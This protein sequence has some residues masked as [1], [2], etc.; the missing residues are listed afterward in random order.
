MSQIYSQS[1]DLIAFFGTGDTP[2]ADNF[3]SL[4]KSKAVYDGSLPKISGSGTSTGSFQELKTSK[5]NA[6]VG[7]NITLS[8]SLT[9]FTDKTYN[10]GSDSSRI[11]MVN[12]VTASINDVSSSLIPH[13]D[14]A[15]DLGSNDKLYSNIKGASGSFNIISSSL[16]PKEDNDLDLGTS[17]R[18]WKD[19][20]ITGTSYIDK[21]VNTSIPSVTGSMIV[22]GALL[23]G[24]DDSFDLGASGT[25]WK[26]L[27]V[28]GT[29]YIDTLSISALAKDIDIH[30][31][32]CSDNLLQ[33]SGTIHAHADNTY[34]LGTSTKE[35]KDLYIDGV[36]Y[37]DT[38]GASTGDPGVDAYIATATVSTIAASGSY[39][40][41]IAISGSLVPGND[42]SVDL[43][44]STKEFKDL[45]ID[46]VANIDTIGAADDEVANAYVNISTLS[47]INASGSVTDSITISGSL[48]PGANTS[49]HNLGTSSAQWNDLHVGGIAFIDHLSGSGTEGD[50]YITASV[51]IV[52]GVDNTYDLGST[53]REWKNLYIDGTANIDALS[54]DT[55]S[56]GRVGTHLIPTVNNSKNLGSDLFHYAK[57]L[58]VTASI[59][60][61]VSSSLVPHKD[62]SYDLGSSAL[63]WKDLYVDGTANIDTISADTINS[64][65]LNTS[66][67]GSTYGAI[68]STSASLASIRFRNLPTTEAQ[69]RL[70]GT[71]SLYLGGPSGS[72]SKYLI[73][74]TGG[75]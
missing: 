43:G 4:I 38:L 35:W 52:P 37:I 40:S 8:S 62:N 63:E 32:S 10:I 2:T 25:E 33:V 15:F 51:S 56:I 75:N 39:T 71:G 57:L 68:L 47:Q 19:A 34:D 64:T 20:Y 60:G 23:P 13:V 42:N 27:Y 1:S 36:A 41:E 17:V 55:A 31:I 28:D 11:K 61:Y 59:S 26:D 18:S 67:S 5:I 74:F 48:I 24:K 3:E 72:N 54:T 58:T 49:L 44:S 69:A 7:T 53:D 14:K 29:A 46:G 6:T 12:T 50:A 22:S 66:L 21:I 9:P 45:Y 65:A 73:V 70:I 16:I 30:S